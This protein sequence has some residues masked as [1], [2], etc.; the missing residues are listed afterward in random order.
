MCCRRISSPWRLVAISDSG[1]KGEGDDHLAIR[2]GLVCL[3]NKDFPKLGANETQGVEFVSNKQSR[4]C[5]STYAAE[6]Y[7]ALDV[8]GLL[9]N[10]SL[11]MCE[12]LEG[13][14]SAEALAKRYEEGRLPLE[15]DL[16]I[17]AAVVFDYI[18]HREARTPHDATMTIHGL[19]LRELLQTGKLRRMI[20]CDTRCMLAD[21]LNKGTV[22]RSALQLAVRKGL[23]MIQHDVRMHPLQMPTAVQS[24]GQPDFEGVAIWYDMQLFA[25]MLPHLTFFLDVTERCGFMSEELKDLTKLGDEELDTLQPIALLFE[26]K[27]PNNL[28]AEIRQRVAA[29]VAGEDLNNLSAETL[30]RVAA[31]IAG[32]DRLEQTKC[33]CF[34]SKGSED[35]EK[36]IDQCC[37]LQTLKRMIALWFG[38]EDKCDLHG[39]KMGD[40]GAKVVAE[41]LK[42]S[43]TV[44]LG[45]YDNEIREQGAEALA[46]SFKSNGNL[47]KLYLQN[48]KI[49]GRGAEAL[50]ES[51]KNNGSLEWLCLDGNTIGDRGAEALA[52]GLLQNR[53]LR[54]LHLSEFGSSLLGLHRTSGRQAL[55]EAEKMKKE[56]GDDFRIV[57]WLN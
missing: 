3:V 25:L 38:R 28:S 44:W 56:R 23:W 8:S 15:T 1:F 32:K 45:L 34:T 48:N 2:S 51:L 29:V 16:V 12:V 41:A 49:G 21:G 43:T 30:K 14:C 52:A 13:T 39:R 50:A 40:S 11:A 9:F 10:I 31:V 37:A 4:V 36:R 35:L 55:D 19:K 33:C 24:Q 57:W 26:P 42:S 17:D 47:E 18:S 5:R 54:K 27:D 46:E 22:D 6:L 20:W 7:S 53:S